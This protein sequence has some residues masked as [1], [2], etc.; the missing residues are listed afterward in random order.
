MIKNGMPLLRASEA[1]LMPVEGV[2]LI[3]WSPP[4]RSL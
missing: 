4:R 2:L 1:H 3:L